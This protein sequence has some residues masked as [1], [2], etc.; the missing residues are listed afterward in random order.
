LLQRRKEVEW[1]I[2]R[3][4]DAYVKRIEKPYIWG[5]EPEL[6]IASHVLWTPISVFMIHRSYGNL[7]N[8]SNYGEKYQKEED[9]ETPINVMFHGYGHYDILE[10]NTF[11]E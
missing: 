8:I 2:E 7:V 4:F 11:E 1:F 3:D 5:R 10:T 6:L 9:G